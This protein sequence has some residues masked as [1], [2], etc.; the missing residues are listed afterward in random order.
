MVGG[1]FRR[2]HGRRAASAPATTALKKRRL[3]LR[4]STEMAVCTLLRVRSSPFG[5]HSH[6]SVLRALRGGKR[7][8][9]RSVPSPRAHLP[10]ERD[11]RFGRREAHPVSRIAA[12]AFSLS[13]S[14][15]VY[16]DCQPR[17]CALVG[18][19]L[20]RNVFVRAHVG[21]REKG[22]MQRGRRACLRSSG[23]SS[24]GGGRGK[25]RASSVSHPSESTRLYCR[26]LATSW[27]T[28]SGSSAATRSYSSAEW[29]IGVSPPAAGGMSAK[30]A[31]RLG[32][33]ATRAISAQTVGGVRMSRVRRVGGARR[34]R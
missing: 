19:S 10:A 25:V 24:N 23:R 15:P 7:Q 20:R 32:G 30:K 17:P 8:P 14:P 2:C 1:V 29:R 26:P 4:L 21:A 6:D 28:N 16:V 13:F 11:R 27:S 33:D 34:A 12:S 3:P 5:S 31:I 18:S 22:M 9:L